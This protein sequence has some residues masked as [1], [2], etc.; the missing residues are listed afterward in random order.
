MS[1]TNHCE[2][3]EKLARENGKLQ[4]ALQNLAD[5]CDLVATETSGI[6]VLS[7]LHGNSY[8]GPNWAGEMKQAREALE[9]K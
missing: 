4:T 7:Y 8:K 9:Q 3:C 2:N 5:K 1:E 6:F